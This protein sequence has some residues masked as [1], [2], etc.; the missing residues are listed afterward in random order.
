M[1]DDDSRAILVERAS[2]VAR[3][4]ELQARAGDV[5]AHV[6]ARAKLDGV[7]ECPG[8]ASLILTLRFE[9]FGDDKPEGVAQVVY[10]VF[11]EEPR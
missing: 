3:I 1:T 4:R 8:G 10:C 5:G 7:D 11:E 2:G 9:V 6:R